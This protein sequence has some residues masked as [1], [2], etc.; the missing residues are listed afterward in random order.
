MNTDDAAIVEEEKRAR[1]LR[2]LT[3]FTYQ[4][5]HVEC[6]GIAE[7]RGA[8]EELRSMAVRLFPDKGCVFD[9]VIAPRMERVIRQRWSL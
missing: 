9:L 2:M 5:L 6:M 7:A 1:T 8:V 4:R 3:D